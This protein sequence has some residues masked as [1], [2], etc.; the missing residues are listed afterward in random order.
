MSVLSLLRVALLMA[1]GT[2]QAATVVYVSNADSREI[3]VLSLD[4]ASGAL[5]PL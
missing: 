3:S 5:T 1:A 4:A 2:A